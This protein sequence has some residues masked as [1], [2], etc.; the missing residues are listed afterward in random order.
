MKLQKTNIFNPTGDDSQKS[1]VNGN[2]TNLLQLNQVKYKDILAIDTVMDGNF[3][4][5]E[6]LDMTND[7]YSFHHDLQPVEREVFEII[8]SFL[9][10]L[11]SIQTRNLGTNLSGYFTAAEI[12]AALTTQAYFEKIHS[13][14]YQ[15]ILQNIYDSHEKKNEVYQK[16]REYKPLADR[17]LYVGKWYQDFQ[18][19]QDAD[20]F[21]KALFA[22]YILEGLYFYNS[23]I[24]FFNLASK[25]MM[26]GTK[27]VIRKIQIDENLHVA[28]F[29]KIIKH[30]ISEN[31]L[32]HKYELLTSMVIEAAE[33]ETEFMCGIIGNKILGITE[34]TI[35]EY[36]KYL[37][38]K[39]LE[40]F[41]IEPPFP[42]AKDPYAHLNKKVKANF[43][44]TNVTSYNMSSAVKGWDA[45]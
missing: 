13:K 25:N 28:L 35:T 39:R 32:E 17:T 18:D 15:Y 24:F 43:F 1:V 10:F 19:K 6:K 44:E 14:S 26:M 33:K 8:I 41:G 7:K 9:I 23:F 45:L 34:E 38:N 20:S 12:T 31:N 5:P 21:I 3:W 27:D 4:L 2:V 36:T 42:G 29:E 11:D 16:F 40:V 37:A 30:Y 22:N